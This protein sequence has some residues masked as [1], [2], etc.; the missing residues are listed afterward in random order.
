MFKK[1]FY[2]LTILAMLF[3]MFGVM[4]KGGV[5]PAYALDA[6]PSD[7]R[8]GGGT[9]LVNKDYNNPGLANWAFDDYF[10]WN[11]VDLST[12][13]GTEVPPSGCAFGMNQQWV[14]VPL[15]FAPGGAPAA[16]TLHLAAQPTAGGIDVVTVG[17]FS[18]NAAGGIVAL[19]GC[20]DSVASGVADVVVQVPAGLRVDVIIADHTLQPAAGVAARL[21][22]MRGADPSGGV[23]IANLPQVD[24]EVQAA[25]ASGTL[26]YVWNDGDGNAW[27]DI[28]AGSYDLLVSHPSP[29]VITPSF[30]YY[31][32]G[33]TSPEFVPFAA[34]APAVPATI[35]YFFNWPTNVLG[36]GI[37]GFAGLVM[38]SGSNFDLNN[39]VFPLPGIIAGLVLVTPGTWDIGLLNDVAGP[40]YFLVDQNQVLNAGGLYNT[41]FRSNLVIPARA[42]MCTPWQFELGSTRFD[43]GG[44]IAPETM[45]FDNGGA[46]CPLNYVGGNVFLSA[47]LPYAI[48]AEL[49]ETNTADW[50]YRLV[51]TNSPWNFAAGIATPAYTALFGAW[52]DAL[53]L[54]NAD[55]IRNGVE[56]TFRIGGRTVTEAV[57]PVASITFVRGNYLDANGNVLVGV[58]APD[59]DEFRCLDTNFDGLYTDL[60]WDDDDSGGT[61]FA[62]AP[63][64]FENRDGIAPCDNYQYG[65][66][67]ETNLAN[68]WAT[69]DF[70]VLTPPVGRYMHSRTLQVGPVADGVR[71]QQTRV[72]L[73]A[74]TPSDVSS[75]HWS[76]SWVEALYEM[77]YTNG[78]GGG[79]FGPDQT[80]TRA[81][82]AAFLSRIMI[83][84]GALPTG[85]AT[86]FTDVPAAYWASA[87]INHLHDYGITS[88]C[89]GG[90]YCPEGPVTRAEMAKFIEL[91]FRAIKLE[92]GWDFGIYPAAADDWD[93]NINVLSPGFTFIDVPAD[94][95][96]N[97]W[98]EELFW[99]GLTMGC[100]RDNLNFYFCPDDDVTRGQMAK[101][102]MT[103]LLGQAGD[104]QAF[105]PVLAPER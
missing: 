6:D 38:P 60:I 44:G 64:G 97:L 63:G 45:R 85:T 41:D 103:A 36:A 33:R 76:F 53:F 39:Q 31:N 61:P 93:E 65:V 91:T 55:G 88:G 26:Q 42:L 27:L 2:S 18:I 102:M 89:G 75:S 87:G 51:P 70:V 3:G 15:A 50:R 29:G 79:A 68:D 1:I 66:V 20:A 80:Q 105:W 94:H 77:G 99:D 37:F 24:D 96:A 95:W 83:D 104:A 19:L 71:A 14:R 46:A 10:Y 90:L 74:V 11:A 9:P 73:F 48:R 67:A 58:T 47:G 72:D 4:G 82:M 100:T 16:S 62:D 40:D 23:I 78:I 84:F 17:A 43:V 32:A 5:T 49:R 30:V 59:N 57:F 35:S 69:T 34:I 54:G 13:F 25:D 8:A 86:A 92:T 22:I 81:Q 101:F 98:I 56:Q 12:D 52:Y 21:W 28:P 7:A